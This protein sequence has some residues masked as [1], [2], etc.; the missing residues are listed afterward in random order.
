[1]PGCEGRACT[2]AAHSAP[3]SPMSPSLPRVSLLFIPVSGPSGMGEYA[4]SLSIA[5]AA[6]ARWPQAKI[7]F[8]LS[9]EAPYAAEAPFPTTLLPSSATFHPRRVAALIEELKPDVVVFDNAGRTAQLRAARRL[10]ARIV[11]IS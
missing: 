4:R 9:R 2:I 7:H 5:T 10:G 1:M 11:F 6:A 8:A 3:R